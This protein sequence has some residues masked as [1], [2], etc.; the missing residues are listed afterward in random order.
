M[1]IKK[2][3]KRREE[4]TEL[5]SPKAQKK[6]DKEI[7][8]YVDELDERSHEREKY[9]QKILDVNDESVLS[10][11]NALAEVLEIMNGPVQLVFKGQTF[12]AIKGEGDLLPRIRRRNC[13]YVAVR[14]LVACALMDIRFGNFKLPADY[15]AK[16]GATV[17]GKK[18]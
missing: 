4:I 2:K 15:C 9:V 6:F 7:F 18:R 3:V 11:V 8:N 1:K 10:I 5:M 17:K 13:R 14:C 16:C 12:N